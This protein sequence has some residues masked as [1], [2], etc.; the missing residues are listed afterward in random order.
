[1]AAKLVKHKITNGTTSYVFMAPKGLYA[2]AFGTECG[3][4]E[5][6]DEV[7]DLLPV[8]PVAKLLQSKVAKRLTLKVRKGTKIYRCKVIVA[9]G[10]LVAA[11]AG[12]LTKTIG[13][14]GVV[15]NGGDVI[16][17]YQPLNATAY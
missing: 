3:V 10:K 14:E 11:E 15:M 12:L 7:D 9:S 1:M 17:A 6:T 4:T 2:G 13:T 5:V 16:D 8:V